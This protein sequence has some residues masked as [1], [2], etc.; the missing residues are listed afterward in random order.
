M[1]T[2]V[3]NS[4][5][6][7]RFLWKSAN[8]WSFPRSSE[9]AFRLGSRSQRHFFLWHVEGFCGDTNNGSGLAPIWLIIAG[10]SLTPG[11]EQGL[12]A[13]L[14][15]LLGTL[16]RGCAAGLKAAWVIMILEWAFM[17]TSNVT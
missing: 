8:E 5:L 6:R 9:V 13:L 7:R 17:W 10:G 12:G 15:G 14:C 16:P 3:V 1:A 4:L 2:A 11:G